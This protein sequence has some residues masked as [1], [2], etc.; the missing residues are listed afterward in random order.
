VQVLGGIFV[1]FG[2]IFGALTVLP[3]A[4]FVIWFCLASVA[5]SATSLAA[6]RSTGLG[7]CRDGIRV[8]WIYGWE[9]WVPWSEIE[10]FDT[11]VQYGRGPYRTIIVVFA[12]R[13]PLRAPGCSFSGMKVPPMLA[14]LEKQRMTYS[15][16]AGRSQER[17][18]P[19]GPPW[20][21]SRP[22]WE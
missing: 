2:I 3:G 13:K 19:S 10:R 8:R 5:I 17:P 16:Q 11:I 1:V 14:A 4:L 22:P 21:S 9:R 15:G 20:D 12:D 6:A 18:A 7:I